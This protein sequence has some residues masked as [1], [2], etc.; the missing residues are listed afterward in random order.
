MFEQESLQNE[1]MEKYIWNQP[2]EH[3]KM[4]STKWENTSPFFGQNPARHKMMVYEGHV[5]T[6]F[7]PE[8]SRGIADDTPAPYTREN[9]QIWARKNCYQSIYWYLSVSTHSTFFTGFWEMLIDLVYEVPVRLRLVFHLPFHQ[10]WIT[11]WQWLLT[12]T[13]HILQMEK[14]PANTERMYKTY[15]ATQHK[16]YTFTYQP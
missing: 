14:N 11:W 5:P 3:P 15:S 12:M 16:F 4:V 2:L 1:S 13:R 9:W 10:L 7:M 8:I 6:H